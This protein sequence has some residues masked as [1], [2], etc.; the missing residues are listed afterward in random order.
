MATTIF[1][2]E[3]HRRDTE[4]QRKQKTEFESAEEAED[5]ENR[6]GLQTDR[7]IAEAIFQTLF[8]ASLRLCGA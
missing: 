2:E 7:E 5:A 1:I 3:I 6:Q 4:T 8:S